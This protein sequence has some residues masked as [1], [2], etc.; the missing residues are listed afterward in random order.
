M[1]HI[2][3]I[4]SNKSYIVLKENTM[5]RLE[6]LKR[7]LKPGAVYRRSDLAEWSKSVDR[8]ARA[9]LDTGVLKKLRTG[10]YYCPKKSVFGDVPADDNKLVKSFLKDDQFLLTSPNAYNSLGLGTTQL[11]NTQVVYNY[12]RHGVYELGGRKFEFRRKYQFPN[13]VTEEFLLVDLMNN[14]NSLAEDQEALRA[15]V[16]EKARSMEAKKLKQAVKKYANNTSK[17]YFDSVLTHAT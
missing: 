8:H 9:L 11:Y 1:N 12:K 2:L 6:Q 5:R 14:L 16:R 3:V 15:R 4:L 10:L 17:K 7:H 13:K